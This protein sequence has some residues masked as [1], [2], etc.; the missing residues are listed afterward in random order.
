MIRS[1]VNRFT[2]TG[3]GS[4]AGPTAIPNPVITAL[5]PSSGP[6]A[7][8]TVVKVIGTGFVDGDQVTE[9]GNATTE[10]FVNSS[11]INMTTPAD[12]AGTYDVLVV[13]TDG[14][15]TSNAKDFIL[16][17]TRHGRPPVIKGPFPLR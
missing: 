6:T 8:G 11:L 2:A 3:R 14:R 10:A 7:G 5:D 9:D 15:A 17:P 12:A 13:P 4:D 1:P 16:V